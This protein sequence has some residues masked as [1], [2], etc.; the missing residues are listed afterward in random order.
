MEKDSPPSR[1]R[2]RKKKKSARE[3]GT[4]EVSGFPAL[5]ACS[6]PTETSGEAGQ[7]PAPPPA[8]EKA[9]SEQPAPPPPS[10]PG[11]LR[12]HAA[13]WAR[14]VSF[15]RMPFSGELLWKREQRH[16][17]VENL[18]RP[19]LRR[20]GG[21]TKPSRRI[22][23]G[24][25]E[26]KKAPGVYLASPPPTPPRTNR[27]FRAPSFE[28]GGAARDRY[29]PTLLQRSQRGTRGAGRARRDPAAE[30]GNE[31]GARPGR[32]PGG[33]RQPPSSR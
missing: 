10:P 14:K 17:G 31:E 18:P 29:L 5:S 9:T 7:A 2:A 26:R 30:E 19:R 12:A 4:A 25:K 28:G 15:W 24:F 23:R 8:G 1:Y 32:G 27:F 6:V 11:G 13:F 33:W 20:K 22:S 21:L 16:H 3:E